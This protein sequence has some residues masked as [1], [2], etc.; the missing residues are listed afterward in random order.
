MN[1]QY[2]IN[3]KKTL[4]K[5]PKDVLV[6]RILFLQD[7]ISQ[8]KEN[9]NILI[10]KL[11]E[12]AMRINDIK[13]FQLLEPLIKDVYPKLIKM[14]E[15][16]GEKKKIKSEA[17]GY[18]LSKVKNKKSGFLYYVRY[19]ING[20]MIPSRWNTHTN[21]LESA[22]I[23]AEENRMRILTE[24]HKTHFM[25]DLGIKEYGNMFKILKTF[26]SFE[27]VYLKYTEE[28]NRTINER[29]RINYDN[30]INKVFIPF[31]KKNQIK[32]FDEI[33]ASVIGKFQFFLIEKEKTPKSIIR[34]L[35]SI[36]YLFINLVMM[37]VIEKN[38]F[39]NVIKVKVGRSQ[40]A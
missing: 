3:D 16:V 2:V 34:Y 5:F 23:F 1:R 15:I 32:N 7:Y 4:E 35:K 10:N 11:N 19:S 9:N 20:K 33:T 17:K 36:E 8:L 14:V 26:Y 21:E 38:V 39:D 18:C 13:K 31:L 37:G 30:I 40:K 29:T 27:S 24:Y 22:K 6:E 25:K 12:N 28:L